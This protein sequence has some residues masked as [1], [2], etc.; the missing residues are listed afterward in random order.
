MSS[1]EAKE[2]KK[3]M[4]VRR[5]A[6]DFFTGIKANMDQTRATNRLILLSPSGDFNGS[7]QLQ[8]FFVTR[9]AGRFE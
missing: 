9:D 3:V 8:N 1:I 2:R 7:A 5:R 4:A 6:V